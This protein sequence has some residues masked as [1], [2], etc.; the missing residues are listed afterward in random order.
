M[1]LVKIICGMAMA[2]LCVALNLSFTLI[3]EIEH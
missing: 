3:L 1:N 2:V